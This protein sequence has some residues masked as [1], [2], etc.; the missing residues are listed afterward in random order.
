M[1]K[2]VNIHLSWV[3]PSPRYDSL[4]LRLPV[5]SQSTKPLSNV[6]R[7]A[8]NVRTA[9]AAG[10]ARPHRLSTFFGEGGPRRAAADV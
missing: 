9:T 1:W 10:I 6:G 2:V 5:S 4:S 3:Q 8:R 7:K